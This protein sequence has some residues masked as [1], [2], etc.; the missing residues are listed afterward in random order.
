MFQ[1]QVRRAVAKAEGSTTVFDQVP[2]A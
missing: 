2:D 1:F